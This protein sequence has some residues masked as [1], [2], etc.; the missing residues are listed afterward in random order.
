MLLL[1]EPKAPASPS[2]AGWV[3]FIL[4]ALSAYFLLG[5]VSEIA[6][7][8]VSAFPRWVGRVLP[9]TLV[10]VFYALWF[11]KVFR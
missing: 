6:L 8:A 9:I 5:V 11:W 4:F 7:E 1:D 2:P 10:A 3:L